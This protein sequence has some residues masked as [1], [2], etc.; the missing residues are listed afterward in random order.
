MMNPRAIAGTAIRSKLLLSSPITTIVGT[1]IYASVA[2]GKVAT[3]YITFDYQYGGRLQNSPKDELDLGMLVTAVS[4]SQTQAEQLAN[5]ISEELSN[6]EVN[7]PDGFAC[8]TV[9]TEEQTFGTTFFIT[10]DVQG[11]LYWRLGAIYRFR[12]V[13][14]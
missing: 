7:F 3:P 4:T 1:K 8:Y 5:Y 10:T 6:Q 14:E 13:K 2:P 11:Q 9:V 12:G